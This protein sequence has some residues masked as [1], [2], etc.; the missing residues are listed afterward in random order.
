M[1]TYRRALAYYRED[2]GK[3]VLSLVLIAAMVVLGLL[4]PVPIAIFFNVMN[5]DASTD[6]FVYRLFDWVPRETTTAMVV[7]LAAAMFVLRI[8]NEVIR[9]VQAQ[10]NI[11]IGYRGRT[12]VQLDLFQKLQQLSLQ[13]HKS[14]PQGDAIY[15][16]SYDTHGFHGVLGVATGALVN[17]LTLVVMLVIMLNLDWKLTLISLAIVPALFLVITKWGNVLKKYNVA[18]K[19]AD[20]NLTTQIQRSLS[21]VGLVQ[22]FN[23]QGDEHRR[24]GDTVRTY[25]D[26]SLRLHW[27]EIMYWLVLG[28]IIA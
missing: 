24:F 19:E 17:V 4:A 18:Q 25:I 6:G 22:A 1:K 23:R 8:G 28:V 15:R 16:L 21:A 2:L 27:Q 11:L 14:Q 12:R 3:I 10:L 20:T 26:A 5:G 7:M 9:T 13:Y